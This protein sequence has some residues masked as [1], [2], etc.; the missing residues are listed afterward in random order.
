MPQAYAAAPAYAEPA[1][2]DGDAP[3]YYDE[4]APV[5]GARYYGPAPAYYGAPY[6]GPNFVGP[7]IGLGIGYWIGSTWHHGY[8]Y[9]GYYGGRH[10]H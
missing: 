9:G 3:I 1:P 10:W 6:Y 5:Y 2:S 8:R 4:P 7:A